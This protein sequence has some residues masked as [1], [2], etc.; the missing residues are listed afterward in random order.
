MPP[1]VLNWDENICTGGNSS[2]TFTE[3]LEQRKTKV[4]LSLNMVITKALLICSASQPSQISNPIFVSTVEN[5]S[6]LWLRFP[7]NVC[8]ALFLG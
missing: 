7:G 6:N 1:N 5:T 3:R 8:W 2:V 4:I